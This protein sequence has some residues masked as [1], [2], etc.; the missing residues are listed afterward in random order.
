MKQQYDG[1]PAETGGKWRE[2]IAVGDNVRA[3]FVFLFISSQL[4]K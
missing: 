3:I 2:M 4:I 1:R